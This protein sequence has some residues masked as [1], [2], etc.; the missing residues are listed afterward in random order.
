MNAP[1]SHTGRPPLAHIP[2][3]I[4]CALDYELLAPH[5]MEPSRL[6]Y[7]AGGCGH[8]ISVA[9]NRRAFDAWAM[10]P[11][12][13]HDVR[14]GHT[15]CTIAGQAFAHPLLLA[16]VAHQR[17]AH[18]QAERESARAAAAMQACIVASTLS[19]VPLEEIAE[20]SGPQ[21]WFQLYLQPERKDTL[22]LIARAGGAGYQAI[23]LTLDAAI[24][25]ASRRALQAGFRMPAD[26]TPANLQG[27][28]PVEL[29]HLDHDASRIFQGAM[30]QAATWA[31]LDGLLAHTR[32]PVWIK[33]VMHPDDA[34]ELQRSGV[35]GII[36]SNHG[37]RGLDGAP[38]TLAALP[39]VRAAVGT[40]YPVLLDGGIRS[41]SD[42]FKALALGAQG[43]LVGRLQMYALAVAGALGVAHMLKALREELEV[44][45]ALTGCATV[46]DIH[47]GCLLPVN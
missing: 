41:G 29:P 40:D 31:D 12:V 3:E 46:Q 21:R 23:V 22:D 37:G 1:V 5:F 36:V 26:C 9:A 25:M 35:A 16:P 47:A 45:M 19:S 13:L 28:A 18:P 32:L 24:Q 39:A 6:A 34:R 8:D 30:R 2:P 4:G 7:V 14:Q 20:H 38:A 42:V 17:L 43:V 44:C 27:Y 15:R 33:G 10:V 11:R